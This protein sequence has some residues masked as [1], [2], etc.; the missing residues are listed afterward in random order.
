M[1]TESERNEIINAAVEKTLL[2]IPEVIG[3]LLANHAALHKINTAFYT[4]H[5]EF[6]GKKDVVQSVVE[7]IEGKNPLLE[8]EEIL[9]KAVPEI[10]RRLVIMQ[11]VDITTEPKVM[12]KEFK[13][14]DSTNNGVL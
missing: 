13:D 5:P 2:M 14:F 12:P 8:Y 3:N 9:D 11:D 4:A 7:M 6:K 10:E 1:I